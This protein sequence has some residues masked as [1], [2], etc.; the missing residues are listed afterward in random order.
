MLL[1]VETVTAY[2]F[3]PKGNFYMKKFT[4]VIVEWNI[5]QAIKWG[6]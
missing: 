4:I 6:L 5:M 2:D 1:Q 3:I